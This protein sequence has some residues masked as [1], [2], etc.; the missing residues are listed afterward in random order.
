MNVQLEKVRGLV[1]ATGF[2]GTHAGR[3]AGSFQSCGLKGK[4]FPLPLTADGVFRLLSQAVGQH[5][6]H[7]SMLFSQLKGGGV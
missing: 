4:Y 3:Q 6:L 2:L 1:P 5:I 7:T